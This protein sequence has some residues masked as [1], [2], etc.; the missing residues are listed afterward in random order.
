[1]RSS[2]KV[3]GKELTIKRCKSTPAK[4]QRTVNNKGE[5]YIDQLFPV[6]DQAQER[7][8][9][10]QHQVREKYKSGLTDG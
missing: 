4:A 5:K 7:N 1:V 9:N 10:Q 2:L 8:H 3:P 6:N